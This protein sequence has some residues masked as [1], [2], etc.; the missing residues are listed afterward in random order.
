M[1]E[2]QVGSKQQPIIILPRIDGNAVTV[3]N[4]KDN[5]SNFFINNGSTP[6]NFVMETRTRLGNKVTLNYDVAK[7]S[8]TEIWFLPLDTFWESIQKYT[9]LFYWTIAVEKVYTENPITI[10][11]KELHD[12]S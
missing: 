4:I 6:I 3:Q 9:T 11:V 1:V 2:I 10:D 8:E 5:F 12:E 7:S